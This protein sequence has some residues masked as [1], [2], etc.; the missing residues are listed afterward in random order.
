MTKSGIFWTK[1][2]VEASYMA[3]FPVIWVSL[4]PAFEVWTHMQP[5]N[6]FVAVPVL[7]LA[8]MTQT[9]SWMIVLKLWQHLQYGLGGC[10]KKNAFP[11]LS[12]FT[13]C[14]SV[15]WCVNNWSVLPWLW[16]SPAFNLLAS[17]FLGVT[18]EGRAL[19]F[20]N[21]IHDMERQT[22][23]DRSIVDR[24]FLLGCLLYTSPSPRD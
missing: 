4:I 8:L 16:G 1:V 14:I 22:F 3:L 13:V 17:V 7:V 5:E 18:F 20:G 10:C 24:S 12:L 21:T 6:S 15:T 23:A 11:R 2:G 9:L 19:Y